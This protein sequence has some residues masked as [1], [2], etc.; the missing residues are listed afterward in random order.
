MVIKFSQNTSQPLNRDIYK[1]I[2]QVLTHQ[3]YIQ[4]DCITR[5]NLLDYTEEKGGKILTLEKLFFWSKTQYPLL[6]DL[7]KKR[8]VFSSQFGTGKTELLKAKAKQLAEKGKKIVFI[9]L[10]N[11]NSYSL[12]RNELQQEFGDQVLLMLLPFS[13]SGIFIHKI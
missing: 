13:Y 4:E 8:M 5:Q 6:H 3:M 9:F 10:G 1:Q 11:S 12:L 2:I 7:R